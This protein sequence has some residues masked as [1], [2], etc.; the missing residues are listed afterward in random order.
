MRA[1]AKF[2]MSTEGVPL[3][4][5][6]FLSAYG[7]H[8]RISLRVENLP[9]RARLS[10]GRNNGDRSWSLMRDE[11]EDLVY[12]PPQG[13]HAGHT[14]SVRIINMESGNGETLALHE[15]A[16]EPSA[17]QARTAGKAASLAAS[18]ELRKLREELANAKAALRTREREL[19]EEQAQTA[20]ARAD[21]S[22]YETALGDA[23][24]QFESELKARLAA[25]EADATTR[26][27]AGR[28]AW[29][30][31][32]NRRLQESEARAQLRLEEARACW[33][34]ESEAALANA[35]LD[36]MSNEAVRLTEAE[37]QWR[38]QANKVLADAEA[39][40]E[41]AR[42]A[43]AD[44]RTQSLREIEKRAQDEAE[45]ELAKA[46]DTWQ[47][48][49]T[50]R[51]AAAEAE[52]RARSE[53]ADFEAAKELEQLRRELAQT[54]TSL[55]ARE[56]ELAIVAAAAA[57]AEASR[58]AN[59]SDIAQA[60]KAWEAEL[61]QRLAEADATAAARLEAARAAWATEARENV[62]AL[63]KKA[64]DRLEQMQNLRQAETA[65][66][67]AQARQA[68]S[69][70]EAAR[71]AAAETKWRAQSAQ[72]L[73]SLRR[74]Y[75][76]P[77]AQPGTEAS[78]LRRLGIQLETLKAALSQREAELAEA[79]SEIARSHALW[80]AEEAVRLAAAE[81]KWCEE[82]EQALEKLRHE[83][84]EAVTPS[85]SGASKFH[86]LDGELDRLRTALAQREAE[87]ADTRGDL[88]RARERWKTDL[89]RTLDVSK[90]AWLAEEEQR[91]K[92]ARAEW[93]REERAAHDAC[94]E[95]E[96]DTPR[97]HLRFFRDAT[98]GVLLAAAAMFVYREVAPGITANGYLRTTPVTAGDMQPA[99]P[100]A[101]PP[102]A[103]AQ[104]FVV[105]HGVN[106][107][108]AP[109]SSASVVATLVRGARVAVIG[110][111]GAWTHIRVDSADGKLSQQ[112]WVFASYLKYSLGG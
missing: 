61:A 81:A 107:R 67:L 12:L 45:A 38:V 30:Q 79:R 9:E 26:L 39:R 106:L 83:K 56:R 64:C 102:A 53:R 62:A 78:E 7:R 14:V 94:E 111:Q 10:R 52:W 96:D 6:P 54:K 17:T 18:G 28:A 108:V 85:R 105:V 77:A 27:D 75:A 100:A 13:S 40:F 63:E 23:R 2:D 57:N 112:G 74:E 92:I 8:R 44:V 21:A 22:R 1:Q 46:R 86:R 42:A 37:T 24:V 66:A 84:A 11:L 88:A 29:A 31:E 36:W 48:E 47:A 72:A 82:T 110:Q 93:E 76:E 43:S 41:R 89:Q 73:E 95:I 50:A 98:V 15:L 69:A 5:A 3:T 87:L 71:L 97:Q 59:P 32:Q 25:A 19:A 16:I 20:R 55:G 101:P 35:R 49:E 68:W 104:N 58:R 109:S 51:L 65:A 34:Q 60:R 90:Q 103:A 70:E 80:S 4:L 99:H 33:Q 91:L